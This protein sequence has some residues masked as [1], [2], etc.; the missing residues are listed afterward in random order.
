MSEYMFGEVLVVTQE[1]T[2][3]RNGKR[4]TTK[5][6]FFPSYMLVEMILNDDT[7]HFMNNIPDVRSSSFVGAGQQAHPIS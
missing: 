6:K 4:V 5:R 7:L 1:V 2:E 3:M